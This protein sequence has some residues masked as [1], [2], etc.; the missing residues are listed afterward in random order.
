MSTKEDVLNQ[1]LKYIELYD[2]SPF[3]YQ[4]KAVPDVSTFLKWCWTHGHSSNETYALF[5]E[6]SL[7]EEDNI[8]LF[9]LF[10]EGTLFPTEHDGYEHLA[11]FISS[12][13]V[14]LKKFN[15]NFVV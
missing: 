7:L 5:L 12:S 15:T 10:E 11:E 13:E 6:E 2:E 8:E 9:H 4:P 1:I 3:E 14:Y